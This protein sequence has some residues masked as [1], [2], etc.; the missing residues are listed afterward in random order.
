VAAAERGK[1]G[2]VVGVGSLGG[3]RVVRG[4]EIVL[5]GPCELSEDG[6]TALER[7]DRRQCVAAGAV[8]GG[9]ADLGAVRRRFHATSS[10]ENIRGS[11]A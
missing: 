4:R 9:R 3:R 8:S 2:P 5:D 10:A 6:G 11:R 7:L 1:I